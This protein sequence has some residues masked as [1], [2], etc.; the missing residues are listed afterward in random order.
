LRKGWTR[1]TTIQT[2]QNIKHEKIKDEQIFFKKRSAKII[3]FKLN[4]TH[5]CA[6]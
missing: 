3:F 6:K 1:P 5:E 4:E 2:L